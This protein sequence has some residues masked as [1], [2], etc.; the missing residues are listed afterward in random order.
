MQMDTVLLGSQA[1]I[2]KLYHHVYGRN[3]K[4]QSA[5]DLTNGL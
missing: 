5:S 1:W 4:L 2:G 3:A